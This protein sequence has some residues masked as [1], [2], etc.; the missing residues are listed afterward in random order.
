MDLVT[1]LTD[2]LLFAVPKSSTYYYTIELIT[3][4][5]ADC[6]NHVSNSS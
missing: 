1:H 5:R 6:T 3:V 4:Q 2:R